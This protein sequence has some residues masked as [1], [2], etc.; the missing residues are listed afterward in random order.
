MSASRLKLNA[1]KTELIWVGSR[2]K[3]ATFGGCA[4][5]LQLGVDV[6]RAS[7]HVQLLGVIIAA[8][9]IL[10]RHVST[11]CKTCYF[12]LRQLRWIR[13]S[14]D[15]ESLKILVHTFVTS[16]VDYCNSILV[17][18]PKT[19]TDELQQVLNAAASLIS[20]TSKYDR[21]LSALLHDELQTALA[22]HPSASAV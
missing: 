22:G 6:T 17:S 21:D 13:R 12:W 20:C 11:V 14:L 10:D 7:D 5:S 2:H 1:D 9:L 18:A 4:P 8:D 19:I 16:R 15:T 3:L